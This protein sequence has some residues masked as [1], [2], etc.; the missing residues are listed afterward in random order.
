MK[1]VECQ[2]DAHLLFASL[3]HQSGQARSIQAARVKS[4]P[5]FAILIPVA[6]LF[7]SVQ[8][9]R[10]ACKPRYDVEQYS[11]ECCAVKVCTCGRVGRVAK[12]QY[13]VASDCCYKEDRKSMSNSDTRKV[14]CIIGQRLTFAVGSRGRVAPIKRRFLRSAKTGMISRLVTSRP[15]EAFKGQL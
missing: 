6:L 7:N 12:A 13:D 2:T 15:I 9:W 8:H 3:D 1:C 14:S 4:R 10:F 11:E 5:L